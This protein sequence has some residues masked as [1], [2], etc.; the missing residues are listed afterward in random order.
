[1]DV[2]LDKPFG[3]TNVHFQMEFGGSR[4]DIGACGITTATTEGW[5]TVTF[6]LSTYSGLPATIPSGGEWGINFW[7]ATG[8]AD[9]TGLYL[10]NIRFEHK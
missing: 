8:A 5:V 7:Y 4:I 2:R 1:M 10:D 9:I 3:A 6:D